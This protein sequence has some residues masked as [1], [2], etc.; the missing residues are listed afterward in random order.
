[1]SGCE[2]NL[3]PMLLVAVSAIRRRGW[4]HSGKQMDGVLAR[5]VLARPG[6]RYL[7]IFAF[8]SDLAWAEPQWQASG[9]SVCTRHEM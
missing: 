8:V 2:L 3:R 6:Q 4:S 7:G 9:W 5:C 1:M